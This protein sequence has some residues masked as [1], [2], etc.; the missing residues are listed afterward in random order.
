[1]K[2]KTNHYH[3]R[4]QKKFGIEKMGLMSGK[5]WREDPKGTLFSLAR[6]KFVSKLLAGK[7]DVLELGCG[8]G[9]YSRIVKQQV[10]NL[11][12]SDVDNIFIQ[13]S[14]KREKIWK[15]NYLI[16]DM[17]KEPSKEKFDAI[18]MLDVFEH[19]SKNKENKFIT[20][21]INSLKTGGILISG[22]PSLNFQ[23]YVKNP[24]PTHVNCKSGINTKKFFE[25]YF[26]NVFN[27]SMNDEIVHTGFEKTANYFITL[28]T[29]PYE[30]KK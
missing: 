15:F 2:K 21:L 24:D 29:N 20:N 7:K 26:Q 12:I 19:V 16:H 5:R 11:T 27:F 28:C 9:W 13:D 6:Y 8:D 3:F 4:L 23:K 30:K 14:K 18:Y 1:M 22:A 25:K 10:K 17:S